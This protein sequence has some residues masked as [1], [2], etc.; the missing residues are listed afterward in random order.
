MKEDQIQEFI[1]QVQELHYET[2][3]RAN[4]NLVTDPQA[5]E[6]WANKMAQ[7]HASVSVG[8]IFDIQN[9]ADETEPA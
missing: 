8:L 5:F 1:A 4:K 9:K 6:E 7:L 3:V 2:I